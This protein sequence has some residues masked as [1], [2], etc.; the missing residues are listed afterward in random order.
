MFAALPPELQKELKAAYEQRQ[1]QG[2][3]ATHQQPAGTSGKPF[4]WYM[5]K[6]KLRIMELFHI[7]AK[8]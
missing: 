2:E 7:M 5:T 1:K 4:R 8:V 6:M 3:N